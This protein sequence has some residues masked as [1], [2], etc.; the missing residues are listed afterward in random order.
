M[1]RCHQL[2]GAVNGGTVVITVALLSRTN[3]ARPSAI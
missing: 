1:P 3:C 2:R